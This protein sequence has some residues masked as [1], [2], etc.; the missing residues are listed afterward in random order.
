[1]AMT[2]RTVVDGKI[3]C[4][5]NK[6]DKAQRSPNSGCSPSRSKLGVFPPKPSSIKGSPP[7]SPISESSP[8]SSPGLVAGY[9]AGCKFTEPPSASALPL[10]PQHW[11]GSGQSVILQIRAISNH[12]HTSMKH[13]D[14]TQQLKLLLKVHA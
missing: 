13:L 3:V 7:R 4:H 12:T 1:M 8:R 11:M 10:P 5:H 2:K 9:Y 14:F 6:A